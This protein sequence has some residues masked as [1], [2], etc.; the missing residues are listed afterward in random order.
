MP[1]PSHRL[2]LY[3]MPTHP[4]RQVHDGEARAILRQGEAR[5]WWTP[6]GGPGEHASLVAGGMRRV[7]L[8]RHTEVRFVGNQQGGFSVRCSACSALIVEAFSAAM[9]A[10]RRGGPRAVA[11]QSCGAGQ[12]LEHVLMRPEGGFA[13]GWLHLADVGSSVV[14]RE[15]SELVEATWGPTRVVGRRVT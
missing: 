12:P 5:G 13:R 7:R 1:R 15:L 11:C 9:T 6:E 14:G 4:D 10:W 2:D 3:M 8:E